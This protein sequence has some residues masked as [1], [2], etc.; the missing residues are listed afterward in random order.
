MN[1]VYHAVFLVSGAIILTCV[2]IAFVCPI[3]SEFADDF[4]MWLKRRRHRSL[5]SRA[6]RRQLR[7]LRNAHV[8]TSADIVDRDPELQDGSEG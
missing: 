1:L 2:V 5:E 7:A 8:I 6:L 3:V 4:Y